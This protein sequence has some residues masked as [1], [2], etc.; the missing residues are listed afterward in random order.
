[1][2]EGQAL[3]TRED[4]FLATALEKGVDTEQLEKLIDLK[5]REM[6]RRAKADFDVHFAEMQR[7]FVPVARSK[8]AKDNNGQ[9]LYA[10]CP[11]EDILIANQPIITKHGFSYR[12]AEEALPSREKRIWCIVAGWGHEERSFVDIPF[13][14]GNRATN[15]IQNRGSA[16]S[17]G[18]R[19]SFLNAFGI[20]VAGEDD[21]AQGGTGKPE[22]G[23]SPERPTS[24]ASVS[25]EPPKDFRGFIALINERVPSKERP[26]WMK[27]AQG[28]KDLAL[29]ERLAAEIVEHYVDAKVT[30]AEPPASDGEPALDDLRI[31]IMEFIGAI[32]P[33]A[34]RPAA[35]K[36]LEETPADRKAL[37]ALAAALRGEYED[38]GLF[39]D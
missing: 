19:Y 27:R 28:G 38:Q 14:E 8:V 10:Y 3:A 25:V 12:W 35:R 36:R 13:I 17:Y 24:S 30:P 32:V 7:E 23:L 18:K 22:T 33:E 5:N 31:E 6:A 9:R 29:L 15:A 26:E 20:I 21:D 16:T 39:A 2:D 11:L 37:E 4:G 1:M 34:D